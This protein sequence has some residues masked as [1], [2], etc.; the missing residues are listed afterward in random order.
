MLKLRL[1]DKRV[2]FLCKGYHV[3]V[4]GSFDYSMMAGETSK[5]M[6][7]FF[8]VILFF[9]CFFLWISMWIK[10]ADYKMG[11]YL[12]VHMYGW[13]FDDLAWTKKLV[14]KC[15]IGK[16]LSG[17]WNVKNVGLILLDITRSEMI[18]IFF[19]SSV[20]CGKN[21]FWLIYYITF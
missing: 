15:K 5:I 18:W 19:I 9:G 6:F 14:W 12:N 20:I 21:Q 17:V 13:S 8:C 16:H 3:L 10:K 4:M 7:S 1:D 2:I 11:Y